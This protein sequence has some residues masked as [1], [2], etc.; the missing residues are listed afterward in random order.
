[1]VSQDAAGNNRGVCASQLSEAASALGQSRYF[2]LPPAVSKFH[3][4]ITPTADIVR[5]RPPPPGRTAG[6]PVSGGTCCRL[7]V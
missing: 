4:C 2:D 3:A 6:N 1:M 5:P 7:G